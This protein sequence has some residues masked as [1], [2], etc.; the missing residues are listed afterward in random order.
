MR[1]APQPHGTHLT[2][3]L[4]TLL[5]A[6]PARAQFGAFIDQAQQRAL[7]IAD[8]AAR[9]ALKAQPAPAPPA[10]PPPAPV[11]QTRAAN[12]QPQGAGGSAAGGGQGGPSSG[13]VPEVFG[14]DFDFVPGENLLVFDD[15]SDT[16]QGDYP[17][18]WTIKGG[19]GGTAEVVESQ[20]R[21]WFKQ[22][23]STA[24]PYSQ[25]AHVAYLRYAIKGDLPQKF[26][27]E[28]DALAGPNSY[29]SLRTGDAEVLVL[30]GGIT[31]TANIRLDFPEWWQKVVVQHVSVAVNGTSLKVYVGGKRVV[32]DPDA[33]T[34]PIPRLGLTISG[35]QD[36]PNDGIMLT[37]FRLAEGGK[38]I[39]QALNAEGR[40]V[41]HGI[42]FDSGSDRIRPESGPTLRKLLRILQDDGG[43][44]FEII[45]HTDS[46]GGDKVNGPLSERRA[47][48][49]KAWLVAQG[50]EEG[51]LTVKGLGA[52]KPLKPNDSLEGRAENRRVEFVKRGG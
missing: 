24:G 41:T 18:R 27:V 37:N 49:V 38:D 47:A 15:F 28:F 16:E 11:Q 6:T 22:R 1:R 43:L 51:R 5:A 50:I 32:N 2:L 13:A 21:R 20:G 29:Y 12:E 42:T 40:F 14:N 10:P 34:R 46:Q 45:G 3:A 26:T 31:K 48:A 8:Q 23:F 39:T 33:V 35:G 44:G 25:K 17:A 9:D 4:L 36:S 19:G 52:S 7:N 30:G